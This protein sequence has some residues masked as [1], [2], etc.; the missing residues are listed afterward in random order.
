[1]CVCVYVSMCLCGYVCVEVN[2]DLQFN[3]FFKEVVFL[4]SLSIQCLTCLDKFTFKG[5][6]GNKFGY[7]GEKL[8]VRKFTHLSA[9]QQI[10]LCDEQ[11]K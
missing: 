1:M 5:W 4:S 11:I 6:C 7:V 3:R 2:H 8:S 10:C 9:Y